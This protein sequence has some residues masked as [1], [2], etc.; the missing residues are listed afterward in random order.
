M[1]IRSQRTTRT[2]IAC[3]LDLLEQKSVSQITVTELCQ[4]AQINRATFYKHYMDVFHLQESLEEEVLQDL[5]GF[6][7]DRY[8]SGFSSYETMIIELLSYAKCYGHKFYIL[9]SSNAAS[10]LPA[11]VFQLLYSLA[12]PILKE[13]LPDL[14]EEQAQLLYQYISNGSG[15]ILRSWLAGACSLSEKNLAKFIMLTSS[16]SVAAVAKGGDFRA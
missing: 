7:R 9:C 5:E 16:A 1:D 12:F 15:S 4:S 11:R 10:D 3:F 8:F 6:L 14:S 13:K 2:I